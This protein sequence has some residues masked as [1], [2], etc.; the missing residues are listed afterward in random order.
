MGRREGD[1]RYISDVNQPANSIF[2]TFHL[3]FIASTPMLCLIPPVVWLQGGICSK[4]F[5]FVHNAIFSLSGRSFPKAVSSVTCFKP[6]EEIMYQTLCFAS[7]QKL[8][9]ALNFQQ[10][11]NECNGNDRTQVWKRFSIYI[12]VDT[13]STTGTTKGISSWLNWKYSP[14]LTW[15]YSS[16]NVHCTAQ[17]N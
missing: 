14:S 12:H 16:F 15:R 11:A 1:K 13:T 3:F 9:P 4:C 6:N 8:W 2:Y 7:S 10:N 5:K 17:R